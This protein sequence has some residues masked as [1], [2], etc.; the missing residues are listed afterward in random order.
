MMFN[1]HDCVKSQAR[2]ALCEFKAT[3]KAS[4]VTYSV[5]VILKISEV[6]DK[7]KVKHTLVYG[8]KKESKTPLSPFL[9]AHKFRMRVSF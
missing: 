8:T 1:K 5:I 2:L 3:R 9:E 4:F 7:I 6:Q